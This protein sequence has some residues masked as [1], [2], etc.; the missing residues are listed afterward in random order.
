MEP[1]SNAD[2]LVHLLRQKLQE[3]AKARGGA[4]VRARSGV[5][6]PDEPAGLQALAAIDGADEHHLRRT[7]IQNLLADQLG[8][9]LLNDAQFQ[10]I[11]SR[12]TE[13][14][15]AD[16]AAARLLSRLIADLKST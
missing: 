9:A 7:L 2:R 15:N 14:I 8:P 11:V 1:I 6:A 5:Q 16:E 12:V 10:Q 13:A 4:G 3:R